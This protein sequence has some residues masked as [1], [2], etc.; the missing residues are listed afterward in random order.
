MKHSLLFAS[1][2]LLTFFFTPGAHGQS[3]WMETMGPSNV[4]CFVASGDTIFAGG[5][6]GL[7]LSPDNGQTWVSD[8]F[9]SASIPTM[10]IFD[11][12]CFVGTS[13]SGLFVSTNDGATWAPD[14][15]GLN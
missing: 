11:G 9:D 5:Q 8:G 14:T 4:K 7:Y 10:V 15:T 3:P 12:K 2:F 13:G 1:V 6:S